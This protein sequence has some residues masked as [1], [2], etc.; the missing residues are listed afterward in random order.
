[1]NKNGCRNVT[2]AKEQEV[3]KTDI[4]DEIIA[5]VA[6]WLRP[7]IEIKHLRDSPFYLPMRDKINE[8]IRSRVEQ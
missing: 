6:K 8:I 1:M 7:D 3:T 4:I 5:V 2:P